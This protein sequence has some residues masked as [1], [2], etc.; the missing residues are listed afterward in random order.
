[1]ESPPGDLA[2][3]TAVQVRST[4]G[5]EFLE[6]EG[7]WFRLLWRT[8]AAN[9]IYALITREDFSALHRLAEDE[10][11]VHVCGAPL[12]QHLLHPDGTSEEIVLGTN[13]AQGEVPQSRVPAGTW[14]AARPDGDWALVVCALAPPFSGFE[15]ADRHTDLT[16]WSSVRASIAPLIRDATTRNLA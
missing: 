12:R 9:A 1:M 2:S 5:L 16:Q 8:E 10:M 11:W 13:I 6:G 4:L 7:V 15:L 14:Q 3:M